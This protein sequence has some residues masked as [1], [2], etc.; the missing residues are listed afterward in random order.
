M[1]LRGYTGRF[2]RVIVCLSSPSLAV[3]S[4]TPVLSLVSNSEVGYCVRKDSAGQ[5]DL[6]VH[7]HAQPFGKPF[8]AVET[9]A[10][11][12]CRQSGAEEDL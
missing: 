1:T 9:A 2:S 10:G 4:F 5:K 11:V 7:F 8:G 3:A 12:P 6:A